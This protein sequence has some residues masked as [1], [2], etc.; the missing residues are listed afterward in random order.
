MK[1]LIIST[2]AM[3]D[4]YLSASAI[5]VIKA[6]DKDAEINFITTFK[7]KPILDVLNLNNIY[8][9]EKKFFSLFKTIFIVRKIKYD[10]IFNFFPGLVNTF[11]FLL[12]KGRKRGG[13]IN[14]IRRKDW[15]SRKQKL[16]IMGTKQ[17]KLIWLPTDNYLDRVKLVLS[18]FFNSTTLSAFQ[19]KVMEITISNSK[20]SNSIIIHPFSR[21]KERTLNYH[22]LKELVSHYQKLNPIFVIGEKQDFIEMNDT[23]IPALTDL[24]FL[25]LVEVILSCKLFIAVDSFPIHIADAHN[26]NFIGIFGPSNPKAVLVNHNK[27]IDLKVKSLDAVSYESLSSRIKHYNER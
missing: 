3:G 9:V 21:S 20:F 25:E 27:A 1:Y 5:N 7:C 12:A 6:D 14:L 10:Y 24:K 11:L 13:Y 26:T 8:I 16:F 19:K 2:N 17:K 23:S 18:V 22:V 4:T 15:Y